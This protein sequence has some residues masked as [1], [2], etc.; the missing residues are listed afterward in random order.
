MSRTPREDHASAVP[1]PE[2][3]PWVAHYGGSSRSG[4]APREH[5]ATPSR[6]ITL[7]V[8]FGPPIDITAMPEGLQAPG[9]FQSF[10]AGLHAAPARVRDEGTTRV[11][12]AFLT[13]LGARTLL[14]VP[15][16]ALARRVVALSDLLGARA[17]E[18]EERLADALDWPSRFAVLD[19]VLARKLEPVAPAPEVAWAWRRLVDAKGTLAVDSLARELGWSR[20]HLAERFRCEVGLPPKVAARVLRW[21]HAC[22]LLARPGSRPTL[23]GVAADC[24]YADQS[25]MTREW[26][27]LSGKTP[28]AWLADELPFLQDY[29]LDELLSYE[30]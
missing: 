15:A 3:R 2:L 19:D 17:R 30:S 22:A 12:H 23:A 5:A 24:G 20:R 13:P 10:A 8:S 28:R 25:H 29:E 4:F 26:V 21:E 14:G 27:A 9:R 16:E 7:I 11:L 6:N 1:R 18:L